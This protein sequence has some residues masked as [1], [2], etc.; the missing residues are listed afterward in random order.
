M[1]EECLTKSMHDKRG[2]IIIGKETMKTNNKA[3]MQKFKN[4]IVVIITALSPIWMIKKKKYNLFP[5]KINNER[6]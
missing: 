4:L 3:P 2:L 6:S 5:K 1:I